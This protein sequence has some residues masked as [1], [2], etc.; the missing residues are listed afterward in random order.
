MKVLARRKKVAACPSL[1]RRRAS[2]D[3]R[4]RCVNIRHDGERIAV[5]RGPAQA[6]GVALD[7]PL[8]VGQIAEAVDALRE[9]KPAD[10]LVVAD[11]VH[12]DLALLPLVEVA[13]QEHLVSPRLP[14][15]E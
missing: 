15:A 1:I 8:A 3:E 10:P 2:A 14:K 7:V 6:G 5:E 13:D 4:R 9:L 11:P 12:R